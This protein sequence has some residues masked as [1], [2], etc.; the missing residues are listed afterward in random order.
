[1]MVRSQT[2]TKPT[3]KP[4]F[5]PVKTGIL[6][7][8]C[9]CGNSASLTGKCT[10]C[11][12][13]RLTLQRRS[14]NRDEV[15]E[16][17][18]IVGEVL[19]QP[20]QHLDQD[21]R[22]F[23]ESRFGHDFSQV[24][25]HT[26]AKAAESAQALNALAYTV[27]QN[28]VFRAEYYAPRSR[29]GQKLIAHEL[30]HTI[31]QSDRFDLP[32]TKLEMTEIGDAGEREAE[33]ASQAITQDLPFAVKP[34]NVLQ[35]ARQP[36]DREGLNEGDVLGGRTPRI[37]QG[38]PLPYREAMEVTERGLYEE[39][40]R[41][42][43]GIRVLERLSR[44]E[45]SPLERVRGLERRLRVIPRLFELKREIEQQENVAIRQQ[46]LRYFQEN[47]VEG[48][49]PRF[50]RGYAL[51]SEENELAIAQCELSTAR[52]EFFVLT[53]RGRIPGRLLRSR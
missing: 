1:M 42:C 52:W 45:I 30:A 28:I 39:Y 11:D 29:E 38:N 49:F 18:A 22:S 36:I 51:S 10:E 43:A 47:V 26:D 14:A 46:L 13:K 41:N 40:I 48:E 9:A 8:K 50:P 27:G 5:T 31:Q 6:Q 53:R 21:T 37:G 44:E 15:S 32:V 19:R 16:V 23:M 17:P 20:G 2:Q 33:A 3:P 12:N 24:Q 7:R 4:S 25:V 34:A 35:I